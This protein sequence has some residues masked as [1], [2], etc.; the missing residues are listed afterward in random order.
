M[1]KEM[2]CSSGGRDV[3][4]DESDDLDGFHARDAAAGRE[5]GK[6]DHRSASARLC[7]LPACR[8]LN[9]HD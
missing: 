5:K 8:L 6:D 4:R 2:G 7:D 3:Q 9:A 1:L